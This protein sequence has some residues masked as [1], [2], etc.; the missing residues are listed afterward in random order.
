MFNSILNRWFVSGRSRAAL[1]MVGGRQ[2]GRKE[3]G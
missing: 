1:V 3:L 2:I